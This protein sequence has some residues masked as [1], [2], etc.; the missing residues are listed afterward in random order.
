MSKLTKSE[1]KL[2]VASREA[3]A[4][5]VDQEAVLKL[6]GRSRKVLTE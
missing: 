4:A 1:G 2:K 5:V 3:T 6:M